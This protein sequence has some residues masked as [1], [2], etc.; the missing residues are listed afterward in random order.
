MASELDVNEVAKIK[1]QIL[2]K[3]C[4]F[5]HS[6]NFFKI[7]LNFLPKQKF[8]IYFIYSFQLNVKKGKRI[9]S[10]ESIFWIHFQLP[11]PGNHFLN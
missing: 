9:L 10:F 5:T 3:L 6:V 4:K 1:I 11:G 2:K 7:R 8:Y